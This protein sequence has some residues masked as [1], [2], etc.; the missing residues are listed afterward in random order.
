MSPLVSILIPVYNR[1]NLVRECIA[2]AQAQTYGNIEII[3]CDNA[4]TD[5]TWDVVQEFARGDSRIRAFRNESNVGPVRNWLRCVSQAKGDYIKIL[6]SDD[7]ISPR[8]VEVLLSVFQDDVA[9]SYSPALITGTEFGAGGIA[10]ASGESAVYSTRQYLELLNAGVAPFS[11]CAGLFRTSDVKKNLLDT[12]PTKIVRDYWRHGA[13]PDVMLFALTAKEYPKVA[14]IKDPL[15]TF[16]AHGASITIADKKNEVLDGYCGALGWFYLLHVGR[17]A[18]LDCLARLWVAQML[19]VRKW[20]NPG[21]FTER[22]EG[23]GGYRDAFELAVKGGGVI[24]RKI[25]ARA[26]SLISRAGSRRAENP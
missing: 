10:Y 1:E 15:V 24:A 6:F 11:P 12:L 17:N 9:F 14:Y 7:L 16:R 22:Y 18:W 23:A 25:F 5:R 3:I 8:C 4:S 13:G 2:S 19:A 20:I 21:E 26:S